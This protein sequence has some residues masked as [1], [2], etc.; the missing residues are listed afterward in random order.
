MTTV[1][2]VDTRGLLEQMRA[3]ANE[4]RAIPGW[5]PSG[6]AGPFARL[7]ETS[8]ATVNGVQQ[9]A[10]ALSE[11]FE[12]GESGVSLAEVAIAREKAGLAFQATLQVRNRLVSA[13]QDI[14]NMPI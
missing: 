11:A 8:L 13:Y 1:T 12:R 7:L 10:A 5:G 9:R 6:Q 3:L 4:A 2:P 14:M